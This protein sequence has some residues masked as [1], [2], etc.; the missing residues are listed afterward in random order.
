MVI[1][2]KCL[3]RPIGVCLC[4]LTAIATTSARS[5]QGPSLDQTLAP[6]KVVH[7]GAGFMQNVFKDHN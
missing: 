3:N 2:L 6:T 4:V 7:L 5:G 1:S